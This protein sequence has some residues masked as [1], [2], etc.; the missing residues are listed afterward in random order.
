MPSQSQ[1]MSNK[2]ACVQLRLQCA[3]VQ[4]NA[5]VSM[6]AKLNVVIHHSLKSATNISRSS[7][8]WKSPRQLPI[9]HLLFLCPDQLN[10]SHIKVHP[11]LLER[12]DEGLGCAAGV[13]FAA[14]VGLDH[15]QGVAVQSPVEAGR[16]P[17]QRGLEHDNLLCHVGGDDRVEAGIGNLHKGL[18]SKVK[19]QKQKILLNTV[20]AE[21]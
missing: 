3:R 15:T 12:L 10:L 20:E 19:A 14:L 1:P 16:H 11:D 21:H 18:D 8:T 2:N 7:T 13:L 4:R 17:G 5:S 9:S 6:Q